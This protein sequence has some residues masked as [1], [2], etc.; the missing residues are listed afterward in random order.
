MKVHELF[1]S[2]LKAFHKHLGDQVKAHVATNAAMSKQHKWKFNVGDTFLSSKT[3]K[4]YKLTGRTF[5]KRIDRDENFKK[6]GE[7]YMSAIYHYETTDG[8][9]GTFWEDLIAKS[10]DLKRIAK[11]E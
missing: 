5:Q 3:G 4:T 2:D 11:A 10:K 7:P 9:R 6:V 1:E 8:G